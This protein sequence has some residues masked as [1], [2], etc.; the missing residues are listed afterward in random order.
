MGVSVRS[1][2]ITLAPDLSGEW[3]D[4]KHLWS[5]PKSKKS[6][7][8]GVLFIF[9]LGITSSGALSLLLDALHREITPDRA[10]ST[11]RD[12]GDGTWAGHVGGKHPP[13][14]TTARVCHWT[15]NTA[16][17]RVTSSRLLSETM[18]LLMNET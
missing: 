14:C 3:A 11:I 15:L 6:T 10:Q 8:T 17:P 7:A 5:G 2:T 13:C 16:G 4:P 9:G 12:A 1:P 18:R